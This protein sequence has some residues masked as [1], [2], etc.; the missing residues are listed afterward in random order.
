MD[1]T[2]RPIFRHT[3]SLCLLLLWLPLA[4][5]KPGSHPPFEITGTVTHNPDGDTIDIQTAD[6]GLVRVRFSGADTPET[7]Q[8]YWKV[9]RNHLTA[10]VTGQQTTAWCYKTDKYERE[11]CHVRV[12]S[13]DLCLDL[14]QRGYGWYARMFS[15]ELS[16]E[17]QVAYGAAEE[18][19]RTKRIGLWS[20]PDP[21]PPWEF[22]KLRKA[23]QQCR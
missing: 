9:A 22:R 12:G 3:F 8:A 14:I 11:V 10:L 4:N 18:E 23:G 2:T 21:M 5:A 13:Q 6:R 20:I 16:T 19:A 15:R 1:S 7:A 17:Q